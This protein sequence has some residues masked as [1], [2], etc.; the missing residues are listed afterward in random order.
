MPTR[1]S[2]D[3]YFLLMARLASLRGTCA[4]RTVG[5]I[6]VS[7]DYQVLA[8]GYNGVPAGEA[9]CIDTPCD[10]VNDPSGD[11]T[12]CRAIHAEE[13]AVEQVS[14]TGQRWAVKHAYVTTLP[15]FRCAMILTGN[16][17]RLRFVDAILD[18]P[19]DSKKFLETFGAIVT[20]H[21]HLQLAS[22]DTLMQ[23]KE[24]QR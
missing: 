12:R 16:L 5:C 20:L 6:L 19:G 8:T 17:P 23:E 1:L 14:K 7:S 2:K 10:G 3:D 18:Y 15:C 9:H 11:T 13:N 21:P 4:R 22:L 24:R